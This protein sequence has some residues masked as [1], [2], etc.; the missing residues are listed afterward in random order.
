MTFAVDVFEDMSYAQTAA[1]RIEEA[2]PSSSAVVITGG[3]TA[4][5]IY[6]EL[7]LDRGLDVF[8]SDER[9]VPPNHA[10]SNFRMANAAFL[11]GSPARVHRM[12]GEL[13]P[14]EGAAAYHSDIA[15][16]VDQEF[17]LT[18][19][20]MG[21]DCHIGAMFPGSPALGERD[22]Y[23]RAVDRPDGMKGLTLTPPAM[24]AAGKILLLV[25]GSGKAEAVSRVVNGDEDPGP[26]PAR[27]LKDHGD[28]TMLLDEG[29]ASLL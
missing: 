15:P 14:E 16:F 23:C 1:A 21:A 3:T 12:P 2:W 24:L 6:R 10:D 5:R 18:L 7:A 11:G 27:L 8:F 19:L 20:G 4:E 13:D 29:A 25:A 26:C 28:A 9:C 17:G 22:R